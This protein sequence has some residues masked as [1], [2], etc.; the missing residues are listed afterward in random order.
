MRRI[1]IFWISVFLAVHVEAND[2]TDHL[3]EE[4]Y[5]YPDKEM[6]SFVSCSKGPVKFVPMSEE[7]SE[8][9]VISNALSASCFANVRRKMAE[10]LYLKNAERAGSSELNPDDYDFGLH[11]AVTTSTQKQFNYEV[12]TVISPFQINCFEA[13]RYLEEQIIRV[14]NVYYFLHSPSD[15]GVAI[16]MINNAVLLFTAENATSTRNISFHIPTDKVQSLPSGD[17]VFLADGIVV[18]GGKHYFEEGGAFWYDSKITYTGE[19]VEFYDVSS[20]VCFN[21]DK[22][23]LGFRRVLQSVGRDQLCVER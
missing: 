14:S 9:V 16:K 15:Y 19:V 20:G 17:L 6:L 11:F 8:F 23:D 7:N 21:V 3:F 10:Q 4:K 2:L 5:P 12:S 18:R 1:A 13:C 22:F